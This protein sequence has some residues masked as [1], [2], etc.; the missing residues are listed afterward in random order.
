MIA[1]KL[2]TKNAR[3][4]LAP[5]G[6]PYWTDVDGTLA[7]G[8]RRLKGAAGT[9][10]ARRYLGNQKYTTHGIASADDLSPAN[11]VDVLDRDMALT[12]ARTWRDAAVR[13]GAGLGTYNMGAVVDDWAATRDDPDHANR[14]QRLPEWF[15]AIDANA[16]TTEDLDKLRDELAARRRRQLVVDPASTPEERQQRRSTANRLLRLVKA[17][18]NR[19]FKRGKV[20]SNRAWENFEPFENADRSR[21][22]AFTLTQAT[23]VL[24]AA[25]PD[26]R[27]LLEA[28][29]HTGARYDELARLRVADFVNGRIRIWRLSNTGR[30]S[31]PGDERFV[32]LSA[33]GREF[34]TTMVV[35]RDPAEFLL[36]HE[37]GRE[38]RRNDQRRP[39]VE[40]CAAAKVPYLC[41]HS[42]TRH[43]AATLLLMAKATPM[44]VAQNLGHKDT[45]MLERHYGHLTREYVA[46]EIE[47]AAPKFR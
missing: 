47:R 10:V 25:R 44:A 36:L 39:M 37:D 45:R 40:A 12:K 15:R 9:W 26:F 17:A 3:A 27:L 38:W 6:K 1:S 29:L 8:Y 11:G 42:A 34:F 30:A 43:T 5:R 41:F 33:A 18:L 46:S 20:H 14:M 28:G 2:A 16:L 22:E 35:N 24:A 21:K 13:D 31:K 4:K 7:L 32:E 23:A 19:A